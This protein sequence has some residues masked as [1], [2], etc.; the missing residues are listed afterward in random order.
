M[1]KSIGSVSIHVGSNIKAMVSGLNQAET[2]ASAKLGGIQQKASAFASLFSQNMAKGIGTTKNFVGALGIIDDA[3]YNLGGIAGHTFGNISQIADDL[4]NN[5]RN[6]AISDGMRSTIA[7]ISSMSDKAGFFVGRIDQLRDTMIPAISLI[8][9]FGI[10]GTGVAKS[11]IAFFPKVGAAVAALSGPI[12]IAAGLIAGVGVLIAVNFD[13]ATVIITKVINYFIRLYN[14][15]LPVRI[16]VNL[17]ITKFKLLLNIGS[18]LFSVFRNA[19][20]AIADGVKAIISGD[21]SK[22]S[23]ILLEGLSNNTAIL[24]KGGENVGTII[25]EGINSAMTK[26]AEITVDQVRQ[27]LGKLKDVGELIKGFFTQSTDAAPEIIS[28]GRSSDTA[29]APQAREEIKIDTLPDSGRLQGIIDLYESIVGKVQNLV[30]VNKLLPG[31]YDIIAEKQQLVKDKIIDLIN[32]GLSPQSEKIKFLQEQY[33]LL[34]IE[35]EA[36]GGKIVDSFNKI[37]DALRAVADQIKNNIA[38]NVQNAESFADVAKGAINGIRQTIKA[39]LAQTIANAILGAF[40]LNPIL[41]AVLAPVAAGAASAAFNGLI[42]AFAKGAVVSGPTLAM[43]GD[44]PNASVD[45]EVIAPL[46]KLKKIIGTS[47]TSVN[48]TGSFRASGSE[49]LLVLD[50]AAQERGLSRGF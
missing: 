21:F 37:P 46:S 8:G 16:A 10:V 12:G 19:L 3:F 11:L 35:G 49:L 44:N 43:V 50:E 13:K 45:P 39:L 25:G 17:L 24:K 47:G 38:L 30:D 36:A 15:V 1:S 7:N 5:L 40:K 48:V 42:P 2:I 32:S 28:G 31:T 9:R 34:G 4:G 26:R 41:G 33:K 27:K 6:G 20:G 29:E 18:T 23:G 14:E 22:V